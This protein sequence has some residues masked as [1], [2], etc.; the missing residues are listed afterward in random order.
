MQISVLVSD[1]QMN[2]LCACRAVS[3]G[4]Q[5]PGEEASNVHC[6]VINL[7]KAALYL[8]APE[9][10]LPPLLHPERGMVESRAGSD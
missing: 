2:G 10:I 5:T 8:I 4:G 9:A 7:A 1:R 6:T 3:R